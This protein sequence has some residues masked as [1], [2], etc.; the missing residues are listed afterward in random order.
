MR[1]K[2]LIPEV[3]YGAESDRES[4]RMIL[5]P[6]EE[7]FL[8]AFEMGQERT[9]NA[10]RADGRT[11]VLRAGEVVAL[12]KRL[13]ALCEHCELGDPSDLLAQHSAE[14][15]EA[16]EIRGTRFF[17]MLEE[18]KGSVAR[19]LA[20]RLVFCIP[21]KKTDLIADLEASWASVFVAFPSAEYDIREA[22]AYTG[23]VDHRFRRKP[24]AH[25][26]QGDHPER[27]DVRAGVTS[28]TSPPSSSRRGVSG[29]T[30]P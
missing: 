3:V 29:G 13:A 24:N 27:S 16:H 26:E 25:S 10:P 2:V 14:A 17:S 1:P 4:A 11:S 8:V 28:S 23:R 7:M 19:S 12:F 9:L 18:L 30:R 6:A 22:A 5:F 15:C 21:S 20:R